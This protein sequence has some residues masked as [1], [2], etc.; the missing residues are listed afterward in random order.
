M[1]VSTLQTDEITN[2]KSRKTKL[3]HL[4]YM[5]LLHDRFSKQEREYILHK[6][7]QIKYLSFFISFI[8]T[9]LQILL[10]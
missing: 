8:S 9:K 4:Y 5:R 7:S 6:H 2:H 10:P 1:L 3:F